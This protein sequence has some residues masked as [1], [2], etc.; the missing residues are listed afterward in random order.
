MANLTV[1][2]CRFCAPDGGSP[3]SLRPIEIT[4]ICCGSETTSGRPELLDTGVGPVIPG[5]VRTIRYRQQV[6]KQPGVRKPPS[7]RAA[8]PNQLTP[9]HRVMLP[10]VTL[11]DTAEG[12]VRPGATE[13]VAP[14]K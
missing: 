14:T 1:R 13:I 9:L 3:T 7:T 10:D 5:S 6:G 4:L 11:S 12:D 2:T 8:N